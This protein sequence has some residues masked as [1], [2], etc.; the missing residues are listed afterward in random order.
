MAA[1]TQAVIEN[2][3]RRKLNSLNIRRWTQEDLY[4]W[5][6]EGVDDVARRTESLRTKQ[7]ISI[8]SGTQEVTGPTDAVRVHMVQYQPNS[9]TSKY[10]LQYMEVKSM[11]SIAWTQ[12]SS[13]QG[14][15]AVFWTWGYPPNLM[16]DVY[17][18]PAESGSLIVYY[19][20]LPVPLAID[21]SSA[22]IS[23]DLPQGWE[24]LCVDYATYQAM[25]SDGD[26]R[27]SNYKDMYEQKLTALSDA[28]TRYVDQ[29][30]MIDTGNS[31]VPSWLYS[32][33][34]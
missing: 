19:Y 1:K 33:E 26:Q 27:W 31:L 28:A 5:I 2:E 34:D 32:F 20:R 30:G 25:L 22:S 15:P 3:I 11:S 7:T 12:V 16:I 29:A 23:I 18:I 6:N 21:G 9:Q 24:D 4:I 10:D 8:S 17:P 14:R 13:A